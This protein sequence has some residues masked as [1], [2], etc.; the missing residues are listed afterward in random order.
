MEGWHQLQNKKVKLLLEAKNK[1]K[2]NEYN[3]Y[4]DKGNLRIESKQKMA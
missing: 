3:K 1:W 4:W 2:S